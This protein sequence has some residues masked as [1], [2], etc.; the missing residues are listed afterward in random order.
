MGNILLRRFLWPIIIKCLYD[1]TSGPRVAASQSALSDLQDASSERSSKGRTAVKGGKKKYRA[2]KRKCKALEKKMQGGKAQPDLL[3]CDPLSDFDNLHL[4]D[5]ADSEADCENSPESD[6]EL[7]KKEEPV[8]QEAAGCER[9]RP[10]PHAP[11][12]EGLG[13]S[14]GLLAAGD[15]LPIPWNTEEP[16]WVPQWPLPSEKLLAAH[17]LVQEQLTLG[18]LEP[19]QSPW[20]TPIFVIKKRSGKWRLLHDL[21][22][23]NAQMQLMGPVQRGLPLLSALPKH[24]SLIILDIKDCFFSI[25]LH[26]QD[27]SRFAFT[28]PSI[29]HE[30]PDARYQWQVLPQGMANSPTMCQLYVASAIQ[31]VRQKFSKDQDNPIWVP[32]RLT[33]TVQ[34][35]P[36]QHGDPVA[37]PPDD[38]IDDR[39]DGSGATLEDPVSASSADACDT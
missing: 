4:S 11:P 15:P 2:K 30:Q 34:Q 18:H 36:E 21:R 9:Y 13:F 8:F 26:P 24:W 23:I 10:P 5:T 29:N 28:L 33:R 37:T 35:P 39:E 20:N 27:K 19:S 12:W 31:P 14:L 6:E 32:T 3:D 22:A 16:V 38:S 17:N 1:E 25:P 7:E